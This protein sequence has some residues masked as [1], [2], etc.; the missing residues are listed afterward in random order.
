M[1]PDL[2]SR[3]HKNKV[4][5]AAVIKKSHYFLLNFQTRRIFFPAEAKA[6]ELAFGHIETFYN[7]FRL[8]G[9]AR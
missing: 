9:V 6:I 4:P 5:A 3:G 1:S 2:R 7:I 8:V